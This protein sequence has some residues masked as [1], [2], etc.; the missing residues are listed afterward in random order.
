MNAFCTV[1]RWDITFC[2]TLYD[3]G[4]RDAL[5]VRDTR[6]GCTIGAG[7]SVG[8]QRKYATTACLHHIEKMSGFLVK[9]K[10]RRMKS[11]YSSLDPS[12]CSH[13]PMREPR[14]RIHH[15]PSIPGLGPNTCHYL[16]TTC[17]SCFSWCEV[18][19]KRKTGSGRRHR[20]IQCWEPCRRKW[21]D[22]RQAR[23]RNR[24]YN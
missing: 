13:T 12:W 2:T 10:L 5:H 23:A 4:A 16:P 8:G 7:R 19:Q 9:M 17:P 21:W 14:L 11:T 20:Y 18:F 15:R 1:P 6:K 22:E 3:A 24:Q